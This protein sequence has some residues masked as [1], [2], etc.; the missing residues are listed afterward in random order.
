MPACSW[1]F[2][3]APNDGV[4]ADTRGP[5]RMQCRMRSGQ[6][7]AYGA[8]CQ[9]VICSVGRGT[10]SYARQTNRRV[11]YGL[12][13]RRCLVAVRGTRVLSLPSTREGALGRVACTS[14][15]ART[16]CGSCSCNLCRECRPR[17]ADSS[18]RFRKGE[19]AA[20][21]PPPLL[22]RCECV[23]ASAHA[24]RADWRRSRGATRELLAS[25]SFSSR[26]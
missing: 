11:L 23:N 26:G 21:L 17:S 4:W 6:A 8:G 3:E 7:C 12:Q 9:P 25:R 5:P 24:N 16:R 19:G 15:N 2:R 14:H 18:G 20:Y 1:R 10:I 22:L 13:E